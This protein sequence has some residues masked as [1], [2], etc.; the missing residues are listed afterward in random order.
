LPSLTR[1]FC[2][3]AGEGGESGEAPAEEGESGE[4]EGDVGAEEGESGSDGGAEGGESEGGEAGG[5]FRLLASVLSGFKANDL[6]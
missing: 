3:L 4:A 2:L 1:I 5:L 6:F